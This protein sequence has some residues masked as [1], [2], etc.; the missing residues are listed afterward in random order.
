MVG[1]ILISIERGILQDSDNPGWSTSVLRLH[2]HDKYNSDE[3][4][5]YAKPADVLPKIGEE[6]WWQSGKIMFDN[7]KKFLN[8]FGY[9]FKP[10]RDSESF[11]PIDGP[12]VKR[13]RIG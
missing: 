12:A 2:V 11:T 6:I 10:D 13:R 4:I 1:G 9:S 7:D 8:K 3:M 5:V